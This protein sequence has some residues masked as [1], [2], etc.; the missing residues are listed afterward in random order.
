MLNNQGR[1]VIREKIGD[2]L[3]TYDHFKGL[4]PSRVP[5]FDSEWT[6]VAKDLGF[7]SQA[8][9]LESENHPYY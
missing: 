3:R 9:A 4:E 6:R 7:T 8:L 5:D 1:K 2:N